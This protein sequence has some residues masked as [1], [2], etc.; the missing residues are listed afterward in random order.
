MIFKIQPFKAYGNGPKEKQQMKKKIY[1]RKARENSV[2]KA[3]DS[4]SWTQVTLCFPTPSLAR[5]A[6]HSWLL[7]LKTP[8]SPSLELPVKGLSFWEEQDFRI[9]PQSPDEQWVLSKWSR[10]EWHPSFVHI[11]L[12]KWHLDE[13][14]GLF[15]CCSGPI[16]FILPQDLSWLP[17]RLSG[18]RIPLPMQEIQVWSLGQEDPLEK[19]MAIHFSI[20]AWEIPWTEEPGELQTMGSQRV[21]HDL[22]T[23]QWQQRPS[24]GSHT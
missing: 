3:R 20:L 17:R 16:Q 21:G 24:R 19:E 11:L 4:D 14:W 18:K 9:F 2:H 1:Q 7:Q 15:D 6:L 13:Y 23:K 12:M 8:G 22:G 5:Q 10:G